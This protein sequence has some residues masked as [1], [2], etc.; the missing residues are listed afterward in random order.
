[1]DHLRLPTRTPFIIF[2]GSR[3]GLLFSSDDAVSLGRSLRDEY[4]ELRRTPRATLKSAPIRH[5]RNEC[6]AGTVLRSKMMP[7]SGEGVVFRP[8]NRGDVDG[9][10]PLQILFLAR[11]IQPVAI[12]KAAVLL[13]AFPAARNGSQALVRPRPIRGR[14]VQNVFDGWRRRSISHVTIYRSGR[15]CG[16]RRR[17]LLRIDHRRQPVGSR[18]QLGFWH[19]HWR[20][21]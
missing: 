1:V 17:L 11:V 18:F 13:C 19:L 7:G 6:Q 2:T 15:R 5:R 8:I 4:D 9:P 16:A 10:A 3:A 21:I 20:N 14:P 12:D